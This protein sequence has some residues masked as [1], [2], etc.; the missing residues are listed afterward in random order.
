MKAIGLLMREHRLIERMIKL[1]NKELNNLREGK[2]ADTSFIE[3]ATD[4]FRT[5]A[6]RTHH[7]KEEDILFRDL[8]KKELSPEHKKIMDELTNEHVIA[9]KT[10]T[11]LVSAKEN[12]VAGNTDALKY[13]TDYMLQLVELYPKHIEKEDNRFFYPC[14][15]YFDSEEQNRM[16]DECLE[17]DRN[18]I[19]EKY[20]K[21]MEVLE[22]S[23]GI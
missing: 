13:L 7:G 23:F 8:S 4:F 14:M 5:Y 9:R 18:M 11:S 1:V 17:F 15:Q 22:D 19:H 20:N 21:T 2:G 10:V 3:T 12:Y 16:L 6:D